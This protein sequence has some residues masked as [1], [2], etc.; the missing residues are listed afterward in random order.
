MISF[1][2][3]YEVSLDAKGRLLFPAGF[4]KQLPKEGEKNTQFVINRGFD[5][6]L[7]LYPLENWE[8]INASILNLNDFDPKVRLFQ[9][10]YL[11]GANHVELDTI[12]RLNIPKNLMAHAGLDKNVILAARGK[13]IEIWDVNKRKQFFDTIAPEDFSDLANEVMNKKIDWTKN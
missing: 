1:L 11:D 5:N 9:R 7:A 12:G 4:K 10:V 6:C 2:G 13:V 3:E 8:A